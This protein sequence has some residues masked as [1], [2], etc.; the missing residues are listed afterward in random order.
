MAKHIYC[1]ANSNHHK[2]VSKSNDDV[3]SIPYQ[4]I[5]AVVKDV[6]FAAYS[7][8]SDRETLIRYLTEHQSVIEGIMKASTVIPVKFGTIAMD[9]KEIMEIL[10]IGYSGF[11]DAILSMDGKTQVEVLALWNNLDEVIKELGK[12]RDIKMFKEEAALKPSNEFPSYAIELGRMVKI[13]L[14]SETA[15]IR[16][17][18]LDDLKGY[19]PGIRTH[20]LMDDRMIMNVAFLIQR[21]NIHKLYEEI[22]SMN[23]R[24]GG[25]VNF[26][27][28]GPLPPYSFSTM[29]IKRIDIH[30]IEKAMD[31][32]RI[33]R[34]SI[35]PAE[36]EI[37][38]AYRM[39]LKGFHPDK[40]TGDN[41]A[42]KKFEGIR[43]AYE[44]LMDCIQ[45][46]ARRSVRGD[47]IVIKK[48][49]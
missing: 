5:S 37:K 24:Y 13:A 20:D 30:E 9:E 36:N 7:A 29:E 45:G 23:E 21:N 19:A 38:A 3:Y 43:Q 12:N 25:D 26:R 1:I 27:I 41:E 48:V 22:D 47:V 49:V 28:V 8:T 32:M 40:N 11:K 18:I 35:L 14:D 4:D 15:R 6:P 44:T 42:Q 2:V 39:M 16:D 31:V 17:E 34:M 33:N 10:D 46:G